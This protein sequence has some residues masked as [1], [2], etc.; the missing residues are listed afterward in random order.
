MAKTMRSVALLS[1]IAT[2]CF[3]VLYIYNSVS[4][5]RSLA[6]TFG[7]TAYHFCIRLIV[8]A[9]F[10]FFMKNR[11]DYTKKWYRVSK[12]EQRLYTKLKVK[13]WKNKMPTYDVDI[14]DASKHS[15]DEI[16]QASCQ[17]ELVH[18]TDIVLS[19]VPIIFSVWFGS[20]A[21]FII[22][23]VLGALFDLIFV[24]MQRYNRPRL[25]KLANK[26]KRA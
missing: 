15:W 13:K 1:V 22:T 26:S 2:I 10:N 21:V 17:A 18:E 5:F 9:L 23:S 24:I 6:I 3:S 11:A 16:A 20:L 4:V 14:F 7:T 8:G 25:I 12:R 19:F